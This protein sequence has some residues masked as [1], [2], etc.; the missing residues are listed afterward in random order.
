MA[1][2]TGVVDQP[3]LI[4][5]HVLRN[6]RDRSTEELFE[7]LGVFDAGPARMGNGATVDK[8]VLGSGSWARAVKKGVDDA[9]GESVGV[10]GVRVAM[11]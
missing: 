5:Q 6:P 7:R 3:A 11:Q 1:A 2:W 8:A 10:G 9:G 4:D